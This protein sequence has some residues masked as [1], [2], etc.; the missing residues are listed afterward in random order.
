VRVALNDIPQAI[1]L[2]YGMDLLV[3]DGFVY[4][5]ITKGMYGL[6]KTGILANDDLVLHLSKYGY[7]QYAHT[8][9]LFTR[10]TRSISCCLAVDDSGVRYVGK[11][12]AQHLINVLQQQYTITTD[13]NGAL[14]VGLHLNWDYKQRTVDI[15]KHNYVTKALELFKHQ[16]PT[17]PKLAPHMHTPPQDGAKVQLTLPPDKSP[18]LSANQ[19][20]RLQQ[21]IVSFL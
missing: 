7:I 4:F 21:M 16:P 10:Q 19:F 11:E 3:I 18:A 13:W 9:G 15:S 1:I 2:H 6:P 5:E 20:E 8:P 12:H 14:Y 17:T